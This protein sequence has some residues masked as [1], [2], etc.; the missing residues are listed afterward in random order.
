MRILSGTAAECLDSNRA[1]DGTTQGDRN[2]AL[3]KIGV[4]VEAKNNVF[5]IDSFIRYIE[6]GGY[7]IVSG[8]YEYVP[9]W[10]SGDNEFDGS[11]AVFVCDYKVQVSFPNGGSCPGFLVGDG[12]NDGRVDYPSGERAP[13]GMVWWPDY[14]MDAYARARA[15]TTE[16]PPRLRKLGARGDYA[17]VRPTPS[18]A[19]APLGKL[20]GERLAHAGTV[21]G[22]SVGGDRRWYRVWW[23]TLGVI[24]YCHASVVKEI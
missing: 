21:I 17:N 10:L 19:N 9:D 6:S 1:N 15:W 3:G 5:T 23:P 13:K 24:A 8:D 20:T 11:H 22:S 7:A 18:T 4:P 2:T 12:L 16:V 14:I